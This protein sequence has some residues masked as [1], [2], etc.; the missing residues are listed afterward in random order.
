MLNKGAKLIIFMKSKE[1]QFPCRIC[2]TIYDNPYFQRLCLAQGSPPEQLPRGTVFTFDEPGVREEYEFLIKFFRVHPN[3][4]LN[5]Y[6]SKKIFIRD[7]KK[8]SKLEYD[9]AYTGYS[10]VTGVNRDG[11]SLIGRKNRRLSGEEAS[12]MCRKYSLVVER[13]RVLEKT[14]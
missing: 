1:N 8:G 13:S 9:F 10:I 2:N 3:K 4:H 7:P 14:E 6:F 5:Y 12:E 11:L